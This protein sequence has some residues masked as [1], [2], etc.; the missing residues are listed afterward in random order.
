MRISMSLCEGTPWGAAASLPVPGAPETPPAQ[1][2]GAMSSGPAAPSEHATCNGELGLK[3]KKDDAQ[4][5]RG[6]QTSPRHLSADRDAMKA[7]E[8]VQWK[9]NIFRR[10]MQ[11]LKSAGQV[12]R[13]LILH[14]A[15]VALYA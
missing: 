3:A 14:L 10:K 15:N 1:E 9:L 12:K 4:S 5:P 2:A 13:S 6:S 7:R 11:E 8:E